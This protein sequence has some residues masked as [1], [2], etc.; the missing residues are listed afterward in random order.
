MRD[1]IQK[2]SRNAERIFPYLGGEEVNTDPRHAHHRWCIDFNDFPLRRENMPKAWAEMDQRER[3][4]CRTRGLVP[5][6]YPEPV[7]TDWPDLLEII[8]QLVKPNRDGQ[9]RDALRE[10]WWQYAEKRPGLRAAIGGLQQVYVTGAAAVMH[11]MIACQSAATVFSHKVIVFA[12]SSYATFATLQSRLHELWSR[13]FGTTFG[14]VDALTYNPT[15]VFRPF[16]FPRFED[17]SL[18]ICGSEYLDF[19][20]SIMIKNN[21]GL[22]KTYNR[23]HDS[24]D[25]AVDIQRLRKLHH[26]MD[27]SVL[28]VYGWDDLANTATSEFLTEDSEPEHRYQG[29]LFWPAPFRDEVLSRLL[30]LNRARA[31]EEQAAG[32]SPFANSASEETEAEER[33]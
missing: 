24:A 11:H 4:R 33:V 32:L 2:N 30:D 10:R 3:A 29:R 5:A 16:P 1:L 22:T 25:G 6:D 26:A 28:Q 15:Q 13:E 12:D 27:V 7:A 23:F 31:R 20:S 18:E 21:E 9:K 14:S 17:N 19:R 8:R